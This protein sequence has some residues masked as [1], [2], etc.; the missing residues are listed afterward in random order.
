MKQHLEAE[1]EESSKKGGNS[2]KPNKTG[3][4]RGTG[5]LKRNH[6]NGGQKQ[7]QKWSSKSS[8]NGVQKQVKKQDE[9][10]AN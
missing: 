4:F 3:D 5:Q 9:N 6:E 7:G 1:F 8:K 10:R 2:Q